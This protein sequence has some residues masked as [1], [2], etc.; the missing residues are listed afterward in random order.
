MCSNPDNVQTQDQKDEL[1]HGLASSTNGGDTFTPE[2]IKK[3]LDMLKFLFGIVSSGGGRRRRSIGNSNPV[4]ARTPSEVINS[5]IS[6][7]VLCPFIP[8]F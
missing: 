2:S 4:L 3:I 6:Y 1:T 5:C 8:F 7:V